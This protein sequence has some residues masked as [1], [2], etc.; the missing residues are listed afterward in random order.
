MKK[1]MSYGVKELEQDL[2]AVTGAVLAIWVVLLVGM[3]AL[4]LGYIK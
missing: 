3:W 4:H 1:R 2:Y